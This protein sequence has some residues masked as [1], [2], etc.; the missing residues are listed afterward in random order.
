MC[1][2]WCHLAQESI[3]IVKSQSNEPKNMLGDR[4]NSIKIVI[5]LDIFCGATLMPC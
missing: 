3:A 2:S 1:V 5:L 4:Q